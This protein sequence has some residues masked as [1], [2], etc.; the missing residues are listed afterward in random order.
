MLY[1]SI[2]TAGQFRD[3]FVAAGRGTQF[4][5]DALNLIFDFMDGLDD[6][7]LDVVAICCEYAEMDEDEIRDYYSVDEDETIEDYLADNTTYLGQTRE[8]QYV[9]IQH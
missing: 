8:G 1:R 6:Q 5:Y 4:S 9:F 7:E 2:N 3:A